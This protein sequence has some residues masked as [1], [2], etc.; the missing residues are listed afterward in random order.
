MIINAFPIQSITSY[1][2]LQNSYSVPGMSPQY[3]GVTIKGHKYLTKIEFIEFPAGPG[4]R[5]TN[6]NINL[7][8]GKGF[9]SENN[10]WLKIN[11]M[12]ASLFPGER[13]SQAPSRRHCLMYR[14]PARAWM[15]R[16]G[17][18]GGP[19]GFE[20]KGKLATSTTSWLALRVFWPS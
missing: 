18:G 19:S 16:K 1:K 5:S 4:R 13:L 6:S 9:R 20:N 14:L 3:K 10:E 8:R 17:K 12:F 11:Q 7:P 2:Q 15:A